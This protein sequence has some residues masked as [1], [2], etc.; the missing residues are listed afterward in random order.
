MNMSE[1]DKRTVKIGGAVLLA[2][3]VL[4]FGVMPMVNAWQAARDKVDAYQASLVSLQT[5]LD[6]RAMAMQ[7]LRQKYG[8][9]VDEDLLSEEHTRVVFPQ[10]V[11][12]A[13]RQGGLNV[14]NV[15]VPSVRRVRELPGVSM[16]TVRVEGTCEGG[17]MPRVLASLAA[18][19]RWTIV[20]RFET[21]MAQPG[22]RQS[23]NV[24]LTLSS[25][26][27]AS[28]QPTTGATR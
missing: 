18:C 23:W 27:Q 1:R 17:A 9:A 24:R 14:T 25:P 11:Q 3:L 28:A 19:E 22:N 2:A 16:V 8:E 26:A 5:T 13:L 4:K 6:Q 10:A 12:Q 7:V 20:D 15:Q 21:S